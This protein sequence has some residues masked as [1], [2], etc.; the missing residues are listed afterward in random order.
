MEIRQWADSGRPAL[1]MHPSGIRISFAEL[2]SAANRLAHHFRTA[3]LGEG[4]VVAV[5]MDNTEHN[6]AVLWAARRAGL[7]YATVN[8]HLTPAEAAYIIGDCGAKAI[9]ASR[10]LRDVCVALEP[11]LGRGLPA[12]RL[13]ADT[14]VDGWQRYPDCVADC[15]DTP[16]PDEREGDLLQYSS[17]TT[18]KPK[19]IRRPLPACSPRDAGVMLAPLLRAIGVDDRAVYLSPAPLYHTAPSFWSMSAQALGATVVV[20]DKFDPLAT[21]EA[22]QTHRVTHGQFV[23]TMFVRMLKMPAEARAGYDVS[24]LRRVVH[25]AA[26]CPPEIKRQMI[27]WWGPIVDE[28][29]GS[30]EGVGVTFIRADEWL[31]HPGSVGRPVAGVAHIVGDDGRELPPG[32]PGDIYFEGA[33]SF[34]YLNDPVKTAA[35][36]NDRGWV[37]VGDIG[38]LDDDGYLYL[39]DRRHHMIISG[40]V[41]IYPQEAEDLLISHPRVLDAAVFGVPDAAMGQTVKAVVQALDPAEATD[42]FADELMGWLQDRLAHYKCPRSLSFAPELPRTAVGKLDKRH[43]I[44]H[45]SL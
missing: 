3:G 27:Q 42:A 35:A 22:I 7:Y 44:R 20:L 14:D 41:N 11:H 39:T 33:G 21:L 18:G 24:S 26:P 45:H 16:L 37:G 40:G 34:S 9:V 32:T 8:T 5:L 25:A 2:E 4:D 29:Y 28:F 43:L 23:P 12:L 6:H 10:T 15:P 36:H 17:G 31:A 13:I 19:G 38:Y 30:S 1:I